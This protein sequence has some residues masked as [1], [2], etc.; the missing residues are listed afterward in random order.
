MTDG[1]FVEAV[2]KNRR[3]PVKLDERVFTPND[4][5]EREEKQYSATALNL[6]TLTGLRDY[7][8]SALD[9]STPTALHVIDHETVQLV[10]ALEPDARYRRNVYATAVVPGCTGFA[11]ETFMESE[12]FIIGLQSLF[13]DTAER[14]DLLKFVA[15]I[16]ENTVRDTTD[17]GYAQEVVVR[18]AVELTR[19]AVPNPAVLKP[20][21]TFREVGQP[22]SKFLLR[23]REGG[24][25]KPT[26]AL[27]E[28]D[29]GAW[30]L[31]AI[32]SIA[33]WLRK[34]VP[35]VPVIA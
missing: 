27:F 9:P 7:I 21:R 5:T 8:A 33:A 26:L 34:E 20:W 25:D 32:E 31:A 13:D 29:G 30:Q 17:S 19:A 3:E 22:S 15:S 35:G 23:V 4:W 10:G 14:N 28:S 16:K 1:T 6:H 12:K 2:A 24:G 18:Q 11:F